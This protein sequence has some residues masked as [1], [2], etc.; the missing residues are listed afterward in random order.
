MSEEIEIDMSSI[1]IHINDQKIDHQFKFKKELRYLIVLLMSIYR[2][3]VANQ[4]NQ[5]LLVN[6]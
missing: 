2:K 1:R 3:D 4:I 5:A 6:L